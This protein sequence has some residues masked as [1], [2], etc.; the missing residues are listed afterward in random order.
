MFILHIIALK[1]QLSFNYPNKKSMLKSICYFFLEILNIVTSFYTYF[2]YTQ[3]S[4]KKLNLN[5][6]K[7]NC[8]NFLKEFLPELHRHFVTHAF[9]PS[10]YCSSWFLTLFTTS[11]PLPL[12]CRIFDIFLNEVSKNNN[13]FCCCCCY[14]IAIKTLS[15]HLKNNYFNY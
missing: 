7:T 9:H 3:K 11:L 6:F 15:I 5:R 2:K 13:K 12:V 1:L 10:M 8:F 4:L 14:T